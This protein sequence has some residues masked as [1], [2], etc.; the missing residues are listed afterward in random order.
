MT[1]RRT[2]Q[3]SSSRRR[4]AGAPRTPLRQRCRLPTRRLQRLAQEA[5]SRAA[6]QSCVGKRASHARGTLPLQREMA[7]TTRLRAATVERPLRR[8]QAACSR[9]RRR[10]CPAGQGARW[11]A[12]GAMLWQMAAARTAQMRVPL[13]RALQQTEQSP[14][15]RQ[16]CRLPAKQAAARMQRLKQQQRRHRVC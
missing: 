5:W 10:R 2:R 16:V 11:R 7:R 8:K 15:P 1:T 9:C 12:S 4:A 13:Q 6:G 3:T 14:W